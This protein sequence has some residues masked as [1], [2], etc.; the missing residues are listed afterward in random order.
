MDPCTLLDIMATGSFYNTDSV[1]YVTA[2]E[3]ISCLPCL[4]TTGFESGCMAQ[5]LLHHDEGYLLGADAP[6]STL[7][8]EATMDAIQLCAI[9]TM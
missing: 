5:A 2:M 7:F 8:S 1:T 9:C 6:W 4:V 3:S